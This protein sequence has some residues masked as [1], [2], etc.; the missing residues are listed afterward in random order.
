MKLQN[1]QGQL[2]IKTLENSV[3]EKGQERLQN[4][5]ILAD[6][7]VTEK[8]ALLAA[9]RTKFSSSVQKMQ[10][11]ETEVAGLVLK[12]SQLMQSA[13][14]LQSQ[15]SEK[16]NENEL[17]KTAIAQLRKEVD[18][19]AQ[20]ARLAAARSDALEALVLDLR[21]NGARLQK[22]N[23][24]LKKGLNEKQLL[25]SKTSDELSYKNKRMNKIEA[26][27]FLEQAALRNLKKKLN[28]QNEELG[29]LTLA[30]DAERKKAIETLKL[31]ASARAVQ[32]VL[33]E[34]NRKLFS[35][36]NTTAEALDI[37][38]I[39]LREARAQLL[40]EK[41]L[42]KASLLEV[43]RLNSVSESLSI[44][45]SKMTS[46]LDDSETKDGEKNVQIKLLGGRL[47]SAL[48]RVASE[49]RKRADL[50]AKEVERLKLETNDLKNYRSE[51]FGRLRAILGGKLGI[52]VV[53]DR[54]VFAAE[55]LFQP[56]SATL[57]VEGQ[58]QLTKVA[59]VIREVSADIPSQINWILRVDGHTDILPLSQ[60][61]QFSDN[62]ELSQARSLSVV[63]YLIRS[64]GVASDRLAA[65]GFGQYQPLDRGTNPSA[66][67]RNRRIEL[68]LTER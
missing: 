37:K 48:A 62:W 14:L 38:K 56:G 42:T 43:E 39:A 4:K 29:L 21:D 68:K 67:A 49:Q 34:K 46:I 32:V 27:N 30:L 60:T 22:Q 17:V 28:S 61:S 23:S 11:F 53:G 35:S 16:Q 2:S 25:I 10:T 33:E 41:D 52:E 40:D 63:K 9:L 24:F 19:T 36:N 59:K 57:G 66:L 50:E 3:L 26:N 31:L 47:N 8:M 58:S 7:L 18:A 6:D 55:V 44:K 54:F 65:T 45:L 20:V 13:N 15:V 51:F 5:L 64:Q 1:L 12:N